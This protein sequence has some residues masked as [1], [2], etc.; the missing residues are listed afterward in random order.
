[1]S[2]IDC[3]PG[4]D[5]RD[6]RRGRDG[7]GASRRRSASTW[8][9]S[10]TRSVL[11]DG[12]RIYPP[13]LFGEPI[14]EIAC[15]LIDTQNPAGQPIPSVDRPARVAASRTRQGD[16]L[17]LWRERGRGVNERARQPVLR[18]SSRCRAG[19]SSDE[20]SPFRYEFVPAGGRGGDVR[21]G[22]LGVRRR[23]CAT[24]GSSWSTRSTPL[25]TSPYSRS[26]AASTGAFLYLPATAETVIAQPGFG[27]LLAYNP[28]LV[29]ATDIPDAWRS[30]F[31]ATLEVTSNWAALVKL[32]AP[33]PL[34]AAAQRLDAL[35]MAGEDGLVWTPQFR[36]IE[37]LHE[38]MAAGRRARRD[39]LLLLEPARAAGRRDDPGGGG[40][41]RLP[42]ARRGR[43]RASAGR[44]ELE[45]PEPARL[46]ASGRRMTAANTRRPSE[47]GMFAR[48]LS[49]A[50]AQRGRLDPV[51][52]ALSDHWTLDPAAAVPGVVGGRPR[53]RRPRTHRADL[54]HRLPGLRSAA[55]QPRGDR[56]GHARAAPDP[57]H[58]RG[59]RSTRCSTPST[60][61]CGSLDRDVALSESED[62]DAAAARRRPAAARGAADGGQRGARVP[63]RDP[64]REVHPP[65]DRR[66]RGR[67]DPAAAAA[68]R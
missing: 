34:V 66:R 13:M 35:R 60:P 58:V 2:A 23:P 12:K 29:G 26:T 21:L 43:L 49:R 62:R 16:R 57:G 10:P 37:S 27:V 6:R 3:G 59:R 39:R 42:D 11:P 51:Y 47:G 38:M 32:G 15:T 52:Q 31:P 64:A 67:G 22:R 30:R 56:R 20:Y 17:R 25:A 54:P 4:D 33:E 45:D 53:P 40:R 5:R 36:D 24:A 19:P 48:E 44:R 68:K 28:G 1:M 18:A 50:V 7:R 46:P 8:T 63:G 9:R 65:R 61:S 41:R 14:D 55:G